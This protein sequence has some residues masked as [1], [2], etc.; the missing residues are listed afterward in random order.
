MGEFA[1]LKI[2]PNICQVLINRLRARITNLDLSSTY[3]SGF[4][5]ISQI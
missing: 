3:C 5:I 4:I 2:M 1:I